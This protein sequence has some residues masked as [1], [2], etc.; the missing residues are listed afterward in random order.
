M[1]TKKKSYDE[2][3]L[4]RLLL[5]RGRRLR[6][7]LKI[8]IEKALSLPVGS[9]NAGQVLI[10]YVDYPSTRWQPA[11]AFSSLPNDSYSIPFDVGYLLPGEKKVMEVRLVFSPSPETRWSFS[12][13]DC[14]AVDVSSEEDDEP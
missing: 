1:R 5:K 6:D 2:D 14:R 8:A 3:L 11:L 7:F 10:V 9:I 4:T 13:E 12:V